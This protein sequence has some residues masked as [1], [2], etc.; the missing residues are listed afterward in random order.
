MPRVLGVV[1]GGT[2]VR[3]GEYVLRGYPHR[4]AHRFCG[5]VGE[6]QPAEGVEEAWE[7][8]YHFA[9]EELR[10]HHHRHERTQHLLGTSES[11]QEEAQRHSTERGE[12]EREEH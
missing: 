2:G 9:K 12:K 7:R 11:R 4:V 5:P 8:Y 3:A 10:Y 1:E 6:H